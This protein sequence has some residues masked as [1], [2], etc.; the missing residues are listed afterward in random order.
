MNWPRLRSSIPALGPILSALLL[1]GASVFYGGRFDAVAAITVFPIWVWLVPGLILASTGFKQKR[2][3]WMVVVGS[4][5]VVFLLGFAEEPWSLLRLATTPDSSGPGETPLRVVSLNCDIGNRN[6]LAEVE[7]V[8][9]DV[10]LLQESPGL[11][12]IQKLGKELFGGGAGSV[13]GVDASLLVRGRVVPAD[14]SANQRAFFVQARARLLSGVEVEIIS[15][16]LVPAVFR[17]D[18]WSPDCWREQTENRRRRREQLREIA[19]R[20]DSIPDNIPVILGG[21]FNAPQGDAIFRLLGPRLHDTFREGGRGWGDTILNDFPVLR[22]DQ[23]WATRTI[24]AAGFV[25]RR[26]RHSDHRM[27]VADLIVRQSSYPR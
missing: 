14:L 8:G 3:R 27:V 20:I 6:A 15:T 23:V 17:L 19:R 9:A 11:D 2:R 25:S 22:I 1:V 4:C 7:A 13:A 12:G 21:D 5:W 26:T 24:R 10:V 16:R 18:L